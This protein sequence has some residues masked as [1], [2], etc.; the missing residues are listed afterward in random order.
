[1]QDHVTYNDGPQWHLAQFYGHC[2]F[3]YEGMYLGLLWVFDISGWGAAEWGPGRAEDFVRRPSAGGEDGPVHVQLTSSRDLM[4]WE[5][6]GDRK[7]FIPLGA[8]DSYDSGQIYTVNRP[9]IVD[10]EIWIYYSGAENTHGHPIYWSQDSKTYPR[11]AEAVKRASPRVAES[12]NL[13][14]LR[15]D[16]WVSVDAGGEA[17]TLTT[18]PLTIRGEELVINAAVQ[19]EGWV[20]VEILD[21]AAQP[22]SGFAQSDCR[23]FQGDSVRHKVEWK[24]ISNLSQLQGGSVQLRFHLQNAKLYSFVVH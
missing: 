7:P 18:K 12:I 2:G 19:E 16:G 15:L 1:M 8:A 24:G 10:G 5:R 4:S 22:L 3:P 20:D 6:V 21:E 11:I 17:G 14:K 9:I 23:R 13:A